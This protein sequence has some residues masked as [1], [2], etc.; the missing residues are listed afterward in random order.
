MQRAVAAAVIMLG[1]MTGLAQAAEPTAF[2]VGNYP[3]E[4]RADNAVAAKE[5]AIAEGQ[6]RAFRSLVKRLIPVTAQRALGRINGIKAANLVDGIQVRSE[7]NSST[8]YTATLDFSFDARRVRDVLL[9]RG[10]PFVDEQ[11]PETAVVL[12]YLPPQAGAGGSL[13]AESGSR[14]WREVWSGLDLEHALTPVKLHAPPTGLTG[15]VVK[16]T[17]GDANA[18]LRAI[19]T[20]SR[21]GQALLA[22]AEPDP[23]AKRLNVTLS[24]TD[25][26]GSFVLKRSWRMNLDDPLYSAEYAAVVA[27][28][29]LEGRWKAVRGQG[30]APLPAAGAQ[31]EPIQLA[32]EFSNMQE[33]QQVSQRI[34]RLP[35]VSDY[36]VGGLSARG[37]T[38]ALRYP[39][40]GG[41][42]ATALST[43]GVDV[44]PVNGMWV[45]RAFR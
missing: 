29:T 30:A 16:A 37:A 40:G 18:P 9:E 33:W 44:R 2:V 39:G 17:M 4:A 34:S 8:T 38:V 25:A 41:A 43:Q 20:L 14:M 5:K 1:G 19:A 10:I 31:A 11:A 45:A 26:V 3:V 22:I 35:G 12:V 13:S 6:Q 24:G 7:R 36:T 28:G 27:L 23:A 15:S 21:S 42:L 32:V